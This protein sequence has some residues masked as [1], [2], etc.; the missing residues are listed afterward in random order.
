MPLKLRIPFIGVSQRCEDQ[1]EN[2]TAGWDLLLR[3]EWMNRDSNE[4]F[5]LIGLVHE[6]RTSR[7]I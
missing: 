7:D 3:P 2:C 5:P 6:I 1:V 4:E